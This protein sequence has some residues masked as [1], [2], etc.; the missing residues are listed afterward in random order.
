MI[1]YETLKSIAFQDFKY[2]KQYINKLLYWTSH[3]KIYLKVDTIFT[4]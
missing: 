1:K 4:I 3:L 2:I